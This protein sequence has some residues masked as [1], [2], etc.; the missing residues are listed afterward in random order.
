[1]LALIQAVLNKIKPQ[2]LVVLSSIFMALVAIGNV[3]RD[4][5]GNPNFLIFQDKLYLV[6]TDDQRILEECA[7][8]ALYREMIEKQNKNNLCQLVSNPEKIF[9]KGMHPTYSYN[10]SLPAL[11]GCKDCE[12]LPLAFTSAID[13]SAMISKDVWHFTSLNK[14]A[15]DG[16]C[17]N[18]ALVD[19]GLLGSE[20]RSSSLNNISFLLGMNSLHVSMHQGKQ[21]VDF[22][23]QSDSPAVVWRQAYLVTPEKRLMVKEQISRSIENHFTPGSILCINI[24]PLVT[25]AQIKRQIQAA[26]STVQWGKGFPIDDNENSRWLENQGIHCLTFLTPNLI[27]DSNLFAP[28]NLANWSDVFEHYVNFLQHLS[29]VGT[30]YYFQITPDKEQFSSWFEQLLLKDRRIPVLLGLLQAH[31]RVYQGIDLTGV[32]SKLDSR[33]RLEISDFNLYDGNAVSE[34]IIS[35]LQTFWIRTAFPAL[36]E[37]LFNDFWSTFNA[38]ADDY[39]TPYQGATLFAYQ[40][41]KNFVGL[42]MKLCQKQGSQMCVSQLP[43]Q[44]FSHRLLQ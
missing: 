2:Q 39:A 9:E 26:D 12:K 31:R 33:R 17:Y 6:G 34:E 41:F 27:V 43:A 14:K 42:A 15:R 36:K 38:N 5:T 32:I 1:M 3:E 4:D 22:R 7:H 24:D 13:V 19:S 40:L 44:F 8:L 29:T 16:V 28:Y 21:V 18:S 10:S 25:T 20:Y 37:D 23:P 11:G 30:F 35:I